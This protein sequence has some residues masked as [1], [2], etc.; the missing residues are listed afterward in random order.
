MEF[1]LLVE[2]T[3]QS[4]RHNWS[5]VVKSWCYVFLRVQR[6]KLHF[7]SPSYEQSFKKIKQH[8]LLW[9]GA[10]FYSILFLLSRLRF[11]LLVTSFKRHRYNGRYPTDSLESPA[12]VPLLLP[13]HTRKSLLINYFSS[14]FFITGYF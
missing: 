14:C 4:S 1:V 5:F 2:K 8:F 11:S 12:C 3:A 7:F 9:L 6:P 13:S 10:V